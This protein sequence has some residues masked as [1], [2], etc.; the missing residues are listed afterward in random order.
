MTPPGELPPYDGVVLAGGRA[1]RMAGLDK[2]GLV[3]SGKR[4]LDV[5]L[6]ALGGAGRRVVVGGSH[7]LP[8]G[9]QRVVETPAGGGPVA[10]LSAGLAEVTAPVCVVLAADLPFVTAAHVQQLVRALA[11]GAA[12]AVD[13]D[14]RDQPL[15]AAYETA[16]LVRALPAEVS[17]APMKSLLAA[18]PE[19]PRVALSGEPEPWFD[20][21]TRADL[22]RARERR[23]PG[24]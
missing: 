14:G 12:V 13:P 10:A 23:E 8:H 24:R 21:D 4:L 19:A 2:P 1:R 5:A 7:P 16:A 15:L 11:G 6:E 9:V 22:A 17:G 3:V 20:C 18:F